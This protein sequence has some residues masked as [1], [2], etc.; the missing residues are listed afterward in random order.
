MLEFGPKPSP[1]NVL[2]IVLPRWRS[3]SHHLV[4]VVS[5]PGAQQLL[6][7]SRPGLNAALLV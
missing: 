1:I 6:A 2:P 3:G 5:A 7:S 4:A